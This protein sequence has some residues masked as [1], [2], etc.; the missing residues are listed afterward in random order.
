MNNFNENYGDDLDLDQSRQV[1]SSVNYIGVEDVP[2][3]SESLTRFDFRKIIPEG[4]EEHISAFMDGDVIVIRCLKPENPNYT[5]ITIRPSIFAS[6]EAQTVVPR[7]L[8]E[9]SSISNDKKDYLGKDSKQV[10][11]I[12]QFLYMIIHHRLTFFSTY[13]QQFVYL[14]QQDINH[15]ADYIEYTKPETFNA[16]Q[17]VKNT[18]V[19]IPAS[20]HAYVF[21]CG[22]FLI[23][24]RPDEDEW[25][26]V[27]KD[28]GQY[29]Q[30]SS[31][32][33]MHKRSKIVLSKTP[34][35][36]SVGYVP[37][38]GGFYS[39]FESKQNIAAR[40][41]THY[42]GDAKRIF[43]ADM[44]CFQQDCVINVVDGV[45]TLVMKDS[46]KKKGIVVYAPIEWDTKR[47]VAGEAEVSANL[48]DTLVINTDSVNV[49]FTSKHGVRIKHVIGAEIQVRP[50]EEVLLGYDDELEPVTLPMGVLSYKIT[51]MNQG[52]T[53][54]L[55]KVHF[56]TIM[57][58]GNAR[59]TSDIGHKFVSK[60]M[61]N[62][63]KIC[64]P[65]SSTDSKPLK[66][67]PTV[68][69]Y[70][71]E[72]DES[73]LAQY[74]K[75]DIDRFSDK[76]MEIIEPDVIL[77]MN[78]VKA[79]T[80]QQ[81]NTIVLSQAALAVEY[82]YY[83]PS[84]KFGFAGLLNSADVAE[85]N[86]AA[87]S[88]PDF[89]YVDRF[90]KRQKVLIGL[91]HF[92]FT[93]LGSVYTRFKPQSFAFTSGR[94]I[95][96]N[97]PELAVHIYENYLEKDKVA[98]AEEF[99]KILNDTRANLRITDKIPRY[100]P[101]YIRKEKLFSE[102][103]LILSKTM[104]NNGEGS[105]LLDEDW[106]KGFY[107]DLSEYTNG[108]IIRIPS[109]TTLKAFVGKLP[110][111]SYS[112]HG[113]IVNISKMIL[114]ILG[115][116]KDNYKMSLGYL[117]NK[118][119][120]GKK[121]TYG[122]TRLASYD[123]YMNTIQGALYSN[124][125]SAMMIIQSL[126]KPK[127]KGVGMKQVVEPLLP[128]DVIVITDNRKYNRMVREAN[129]DGELTLD[130]DRLN[131]LL[132]EDYDEEIDTLL[133]LA[134][135]DN[136]SK[137]EVEAILN[138]VPLVLAI[139]DP[140]LWETQLWRPRVWN[141]Q[142]FELHLSRCSQP[143]KLDEYLSPH[144]N[145]DIVLVS[146]FGA[147]CSKS[148]C[149]GDR[150]PTFCLNAEGQKLLKTFKLNNILIAEQNWI[151][152]Y[153]DKEFKSTLKLHIDNPKQ[154]VYKL[155]KISNVF[156]PLGDPKNYPQFLF[157]ATIAKGNIGPATIDIW[158]LSAIFE[159]YMAYCAENNF[160]HFASNG[161]FLGKITQVLTHSDMK[162]L[163]FKHTELVQGNVIE[164]VK[165]ME[166][167]SSAFKKYFLD[168][169]TTDKNVNIVRK[170]LTTP[171]DKG[172]Y[173][174]TADDANRMLYIVK[175]AKDSLL[176]KGVKNFITKYNKGKIPPD[177]E[178]LD[179]WEP[180]IQKS[181][182][183][184]G[185]LQS[186]FDIKADIAVKRIEAKERAMALMAELEDE[187]SPFDSL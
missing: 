145:R 21:P 5:D 100:T 123:L 25:T 135:D 149:D 184:G 53:A 143:L 170:E 50:K 41:K 117:Y 138:N 101:K 126:I 173:G 103:D 22:N 181:T 183:F 154:H 47:F 111:G 98:I 70:L 163:S 64:I 118:D 156:D 148:D 13:K 168:G 45:N 134:I 85:I 72:M 83:V 35:Y 91:S 186:I 107:I 15:L 125:D 17:K 164:A 105:K 108:P 157:N 122:R 49:S 151:D 2:Q 171:Y 180:F 8:F 119:T 29:V 121:T 43:K 42:L 79:N 130:K 112:F 36:R 80:D 140:S 37:T 177:T 4:F 73:K 167:G 141:R 169:M 66:F 84:L 27:L 159:T 106:N 20:S 12:N 95:Y 26:E 110:E 116:S 109:A 30:P 1:I 115:T 3:I 39:L 62:M 61:T 172:G 133:N 155:F 18:F 77:G 6:L 152:K 16:Q 56:E 14:L 124:E 88:L 33:A 76:D 40:L 31:D 120:V 89:F 165:H 185:L 81:C 19:I 102:G 160:S 114:N 182:Y 127:I 146:S 176:L 99:F 131:E 51:K 48:A 86:R 24:C 153:I 57:K 23:N 90:G 34:I 96:Q 129:S 166:G 38:D 136:S 68:T 59:I 69:Q 147:L 144:H 162:L 179:L 75:I 10:L 11:N 65:K 142:H 60:V 139:R 92:N 158:A 78:A 32:S 74:Q 178:A 93:E 28:V 7:F 58:A 175:W 55:T 67:A 128:D 44:S 71:K 132:N 150:L 161:K 137:E 104:L 113:L 63:G 9:T 46:T 52:S 187:P 87:Q 54:G 97:N 174:M 82:G 94:N